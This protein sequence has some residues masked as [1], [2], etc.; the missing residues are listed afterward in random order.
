MN[1][2]LAAFV[3]S[4]STGR[5]MAIDAEKRLIAF[6]PG[7]R[8]GRRERFSGVEPALSSPGRAA[9]G[10]GEAEGAR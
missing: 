10:V 8:T 1:A 9:S 2:K 3:V 5:E 6:S 7:M 4:T